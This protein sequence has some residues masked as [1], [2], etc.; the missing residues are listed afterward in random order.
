MIYF[1]TPD[2]Y[3]LLPTPDC[4]AYGWLSVIGLVRHVYIVCVGAAHACCMGAANARVVVKTRGWWDACLHLCG[5]RLSE[6]N[7]Y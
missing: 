4:V 7:S 2:V 3:L 1:H 5:Y 6:P